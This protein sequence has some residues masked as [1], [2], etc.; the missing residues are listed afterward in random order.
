LETDQTAP[1]LIAMTS[2]HPLPTRRR[3]LAGFALLAPG[4]AF[5]GG[6][7]VEETPHRTVYVDPSPAGE[8]VVVDAPPPPQDEVIVAQPSPEYVW[9]RGYWIWRGGRHAW[10][11]GRWERPPHP[12]FV[13]VEPRW[14][15]R[16]HGYVFIGG[17]WRAGAVAVHAQVAVASPVSVGVGFVAQPPPPPRREVVLERERPSRD[18]VW[19]NGYWVWREGRHAWVAGHWERPPHPHAVWVE[20]R[21]EHRREGYVF[22]AGSWR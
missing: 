5:L 14:E 17:N 11:A 13:W 15:H 7:V 19:I 3:W 1:R 10:I 12:G 8:V 21:W 20:P 22:I 18:H 6:C 16:P 9:V 4:L 2:S